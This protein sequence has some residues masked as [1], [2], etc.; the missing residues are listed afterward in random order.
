MALRLLGR[1]LNDADGLAHALGAPEICSPVNSRLRR[2]L[3]VP[4]QVPG[5]LAEPAPQPFRETANSL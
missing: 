3:M 5:E 1:F 2:L 4:R